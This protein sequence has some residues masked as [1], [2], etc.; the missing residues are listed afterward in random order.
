LSTTLDPV[1]R[2]ALTDGAHKDPHKLLGPHA[3]TVDGQRATLLRAL[4][5]DARTVT[6]VWRKDGDERR[7]ELARD[8]DAGLFAGIVDATRFSYQL[9]VQP[10]DGAPPRRVEDPYRFSPTVDE[11]Q[12]YLFKAG[13]LEDTAALLGAHAMTLDGV[14]GF[15]VVVWAPNARGISV[16]GDFNAWQISGHMMRLL[17]DS[18]FEV[19]IPGAQAGNAYK[20]SVLGADGVRTLKADPAARASQMRPFDASILVG[21]DGH[22]WTDDAH[23][24]ARA[25]NDPLRQPLSTYEVHLP[26]WR[27]ND[28]GT[29]KNYRQL[30][31][32]LVPH[33]LAHNFNSIELV[34]LAEHPL[35]DSWGYQVTGYYAPTARHG[36]PQDF[37]YF[38]DQMHRAGVKVFYDWVPAHFPKDAH[39]LATFDGTH[40][41]D[42]EDARL[43]EHLDWGTRIFN[44]G[45]N[46]VKS[47]LSG[48]LMHMLAEFH[49]DG[50]RVDAVASMLYL[51][52]SRK[53][54]IPNKDGGNENLEAIAF[55]QDVNARVARRFPGVLKIAEESTSW[56]GVTKSVAD[57][58]LGFD[59]KWNMGWMHDTLEFFKSHPDE[60][61]ARLDGLTNTLLWAQAERFV[62]A[63]SHDEVVHLK[64]SLLEKMPGDDWQKRANLRLLFAYMTSYPGQKLL[65]MGAE[66]AQTT[67]WSFKDQL[68]WHDGDH[69]TA[70]L[71][72]DLNR[73]YATEPALFER[74]HDADGTELRVRDAEN[75]VV[76]IVRKGDRPAEHVMFVHN[77]TP[78]PRATYRI[79]VDGPGTY[80]EI[81]NSDAGVYGGSN[82]GNLGGVQAEELPMHGKPYSIEVTLPPLA[83]VAWKKQSATRALRGPTE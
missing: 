50:V 29:M 21:A 9:E 26:S 5:P 6:I 20:L 16:V 46:E 52:Y 45:R 10:H 35:D 51:D 2:Q 17:H 41:F 11:M 36:S 34:G 23:L 7:T 13:Q 49:L 19:F 73:L 59:L 71:V 54:W 76:C 39:G 38:V 57:G 81:F 28:D 78:A 27:K 24:A 55:L 53:D 74:Q 63:L 32:E 62:A 43:G 66:L 8:G 83:C 25:A 18:V 42:H 44:Y 67:E 37:K 48:S 14:A 22:V 70:R 72:A 30:A 4:V 56:P 3:V 64:R 79:G 31:D 80:D 69:G 65:F 75:A 60:R 12:L 47:F 82:M 77:L 58:G 40:L 61:A 68:P 15:N 1:E 33:L